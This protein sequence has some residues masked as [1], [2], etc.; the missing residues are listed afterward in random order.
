MREIT[1]TQDKH[2]A[3]WH[4]NFVAPLEGPLYIDQR[5]LP[6]S[7]F[8]SSCSKSNRA[9]E[10]LLLESTLRRFLVSLGRQRFLNNGYWILDTDTDTDTDFRY[11]I[12]ISILVLILILM[13]IL[14][15]ML[16]LMLILILD[17]GYWIL[18]ILHTVHTYCT[19]IAT[20]AAI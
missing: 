9:G 15:L 4:T 8:V 16:M 10:A 12:L 19:L 11:S 1:T 2:V 14:T 18:L 3:W 17:T 7:H 20:I 6:S 5:C 13:L